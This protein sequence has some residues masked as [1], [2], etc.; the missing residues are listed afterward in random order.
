MN[1]ILKQYLVL[2]L[3]HRDMVDEHSAQP[4]NRLR[5]DALE[6]LERPL[7]QPDDMFAPDYGVNLSRMEMP[8]DVARAFHCDVPNLSTLLGVVV[9][10]SFHPSASL[11][12]RCPAGVTFTS[13]RKAAAEHPQLVSDYL[14]RLAP[15][16]EPETAINTLLAQDGVFIHIAA[17]VKIEKPLQLVNLFSADVPMMGVRRVLVIAEADSE[18]SV[19][20]CDHTL[21]NGTR[22]LSSEVVEIFVGENARLDYYDVES[23]SPATSRHS[24]VYVNQ[25]RKSSFTAGSFTLSCGNTMR[26]LSLDVAGTDCETFIGGMAI[27]EGTQQVGNITRI[28]HLAPRGHSRQLFKYV[29]D[30][31]ARGSFDGLILVTPEAQ[32]TEAY[33]SNR[34]MLASPDARMRTEPQLEI[35]CD[36][37]KCSHGAT[38][39]Q[40]DAEALFYMQ[41]RGIPVAEARVMLMQ[42]FMA[43]VVD[44]V[45]M[46]SLRDRLH[47]LVE[48]RFTGR[49]SA[50][51]ECNATIKKC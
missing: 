23:S 27:A 45:R 2:F 47:H 40:L 41:T 7:R 42:A 10:D 9:N 21:S 19:L 17:G 11:L 18:V 30:G 44:S 36:D 32:F 48:R 51:G 29:L 46:T 1:D 4:L 5:E 8:A 6:E 31:Q 28:R 3:A 39:G 33:Q 43:D 49:T 22:F 24:S 26:R 13:L 12:Q 50:C 14:G 35:Y 20:A 15:M 25:A 34:N 16:S 37:V 38:T